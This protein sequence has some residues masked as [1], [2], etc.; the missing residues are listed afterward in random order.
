MDNA[1][2]PSSGGLRH[3]YLGDFI[4]GAIDGGV[5]T[6]AVVAGVAGARLSAGIVIVLGLANLFADGF[7]MAASNFASTRAERQ[8]ARSQGTDNGVL[9]AAPVPIIAAAATFV[10][11]LIVGA[12]PLS[13]YVLAMA[14]P[15]EPS[16]VASAVCTVLAFA[17]VGWWKARIVE[18]S[19]IKSV[20]ETVGIGG[21]AAVVA[22]GVGYAL[23][24][25]VG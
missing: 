13:P 16:F 12:V 5:T 11:F 9:D 18:V 23:R 2:A 6:F 14:T 1:S 25:L 21:T 7:S 8:L 20:L 19:P 24:G 4:Y 22:Y 15:I 17:L 3:R 10:A